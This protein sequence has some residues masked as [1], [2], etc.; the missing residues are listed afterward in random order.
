MRRKIP[1]MSPKSKMM[2]G[3]RMKDVLLSNRSRRMSQSYAE[4][5]ASLN[6]LKA[7]C[8]GMEEMT[9]ILL[10]NL[11]SR[12]AWKIND[13]ATRNQRQ[14]ITLTA[15]M[16]ELERIAR[17]HATLQDPRL[18]EFRTGDPDAGARD[19]V[20][21]LELARREYGSGN[22]ETPVGAGVKEAPEDKKEMEGGAGD[23]SRQITTPQGHFVP[24]TDSHRRNSQ[25]GRG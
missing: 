15:E 2:G 22:A 9:Q 20:R 6:D 10:R 5:L 18:N 13:A 25:R 3:I 12:I 16:A 11:K 19:I 21:I 8:A 7:V 1:Q 24:S 4:A 23:E 17:I 14:P